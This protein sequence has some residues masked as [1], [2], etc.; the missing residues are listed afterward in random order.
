MWANEFGTGSDDPEFND[1][2]DANETVARQIV[3]RAISDWN[4]VI[5]DQNWDNDNNPATNGTFSLKVFARELAGSRGGTNITAASPNTVGNTLEVPTAASIELDDDGGGFYDQFGGAGD[6]WFFDQTPFDDAEFTAIANS[7]E[8]GTGVAFQGTFVDADSPGQND[9]DFY[10]TIVHEIGHALGIYLHDGS[11]RPELDSLFNMTQ[12]IGDDPNTT[13]TGRLRTFNGSQGTVTFTTNGGGHIYEGNINDAP[14]I[15]S[16]PNDLLN[17]G[18]VVPVDPPPAPVSG[19]TTRQF[20]S[21]LDVQLL[22]DAYGYTVV[23]PSMVNTAHVTLDSLTG[24]LLVQGGVTTQGLAQADVI[25]IDTVVD[26]GVTMVRVQVNDTSNNRPTMEKVPLSAI[27]Q[28]VIAGNGG[29]DSVTVVPSLAPLRKD[30]DYVVSSNQ[31]VGTAGTLG[32]GIVDLDTIVPG[33]QI[34]LRAAI[35]DTNGGSV[36]RSIYVPRG[37]YTLNVT[38]TGTDSVGNFGDLDISKNITIIGTGAGETRIDGGG[39]GVATDRV[40]DVHSGG[41]LNMSRATVMGGQAANAIGEYGGGIRVNDG[42]VLNLDESAVVNN[43]TTVTLNGG[44][45][46]N[47]FS[48]FASGTILNSVVT[49]NDS[50]TSMGG[51]LIQAGSASPTPGRVYIA[52]TVVGKNTASS[53]SGPNVGSIYRSFT[54]GGNNLIGNSTAGFSNGVNN[55][56]VLMNPADVNHV[57][58]TGVDRTDAADNATVLSLREAI[59]LATTGEMIWLPSWRHRLSRTNDGDLDISTAINITGTGAG[60]AIVDA[61]GLTTANAPDRV[62]DVQN[63]GTLGL[64][65]VTVTGGKTLDVSGEN[66]GGISVRNGGILTLT[67]SAVVG[68]QVTKGN[69]GGIFF[70][71]TGGGTIVNSVIANNYAVQYGGGIFLGD[72]PLA[73]TPGSVSIAN[74]IVANNTADLG[75]PQDIYADSPRKVASSN[76]NRV[77]SSGTTFTSNATDYVNLVTPNYVVTGVADTFDADVNPNDL[78]VMSLRDAIYL[79]NHEMGSEEIWLPAWKFVLIIERDFTMHAC[80]TEVSF[81][82][83]DI[84]DSLTIRGAGGVTNGMGAG[85]KVSWRA[86]AVADIVFDLLGDYNADGIATPDDGNVNSADWILWQNSLGSMTNLQADGNDNGVVDAADETIWSGHF[87]NT[88]ALV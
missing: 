79:A 8:N 3:N 72:F 24:T 59:G 40:F 28:I 11:V 57:V 43:R 42:G 84:G 2:Y 77:G 54:S 61:S 19:E 81:G 22:A 74:T 63:G 64:S 1:F 88:L 25:D 85:P 70:W 7:R 44:G 18:R 10:R 20:I 60:L 27:T 37:T 32:D 23:L 62:F 83:L 45:G 35:V 36:A 33:T 47:Y 68:N 15:V 39:A 55:D 34:A 46:G 69:G 12:D 73:P 38:G 75:G 26:S 86:G 9:N 87:G 4:R 65:R 29:L 66:G 56:V 21:D 78:T 76:G 51:I 14:A 17:A 30:V 6:G 80:D 48:S 71:P 52:N 58:T 41:T 67:D 82:D 53:S 5:L 50:A 49:G 31:D 13:A 16:H